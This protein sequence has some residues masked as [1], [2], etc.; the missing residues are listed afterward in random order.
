MVAVQNLK[1]EIFQL[2]LARKVG[3]VLCKRN[4]YKTAYLILMKLYTV[5]VHNL[6]MCMKKY[7]CCLKY[8]RG[9]NYLD[10]IP[11]FQSLNIIVLQAGVSLSEVTHSSSFVFAQTFTGQSLILFQHKLSLNEA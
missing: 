2:I 7:H 9:D 11:V 8:R 1:G 4:S 10:N 5:V 3:H 6:Q